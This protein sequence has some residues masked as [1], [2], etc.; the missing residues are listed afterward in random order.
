MQEIVQRHCAEL[1]MT[2][3]I[4]KSK[5]MSNSHD[6]W[7]IFQGDVIVG[8]LE[9]VLEFKYL[10]IETR[11]SPSKS[12]AAMMKRAQELAN[13]YRGACLRIAYD[14]PDVVDL[15]LALWL[16]IAMPSLLFGCE[17]VPF[18]QHVIQEINRHQ[19]AV[20]KFTLGLPSNAP[21]ISSTSILGVKPFKEALYAAQMKYLVR[22]FNQSDERWSKDALIDHI[23]G[24]WPSPYIKYMGEIRHE[25]GMVRWPRSVKEILL[26]LNNHFMRLTNEEISRL[27]L[28][29][30]QPLPKRAR[31]DYVNETEESQVHSHLC[32]AFPSLVHLF[33]NKL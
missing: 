29:A 10:G 26:V 27:S 6:V 25:V 20:G 17:V 21:N 28:P 5:V 4:S 8:C 14:G 19:S 24:G 11:L 1:G 31:M 15:A 13:Q 9:K 30:L 33:S 7:E 16:N 23:K 12:S 3:S 18:S 2:L 32:L 22:L